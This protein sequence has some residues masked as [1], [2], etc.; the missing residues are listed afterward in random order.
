MDDIPLASHWLSIGSTLNGSLSSLEQTTVSITLDT[1]SLSSGT[2]SDTLFIDTNDPDTPSIPVIVNLTV[3][4]GEITVN[5]TEITVKL[6]ATANTANTSLNIT[7]TGLGK[8]DYSIS[9]TDS[10]NT[11]ATLPP[12]AG[13]TAMGMFGG[14]SYYRSNT[15]MTWTAARSLCEQNGGH[16]VTIAS[17]AEN[18]FVHQNTTTSSWIGFTDEINEGTWVWVTNEPVVYTKWNTG[19]PNNSGG[20]EHYA[21]N[22]AGGDRWNDMPNNV[23]LPAVLEID[24]LPNPSILSFTPVSG[25][26][27]TSQSQIIAMSVTG[28]TL[29]DGLYQTSAMIVSNAPEPRDTLYIP[30]TVKVDYTPPIAP[31]GLTFEE[32]QSDMNQIY[33]SWTANALADSVYSYKI[34]RRGLHDTAWSLKGSVSADHTWFID[35][36]FTGLDTTA[37]YYRISAV[38]WVDNDSAASEEVMA[39]SVS[40]VGVK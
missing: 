8:L 31:V 26:L 21:Q 22:R 34:Y 20:V 35:T 23:N 6:N 39:G 4:P 32:V 18:D 5:P 10:Y 2:Y 16:L 36:Q 7:N 29:T 19:E 40:K 25:I 9:G 11:T 1:Q 12:I 37:V 24:S 17:S 28:S 33:L 13:F 38:D 30:V 3:A 27:N 15:T 14:H